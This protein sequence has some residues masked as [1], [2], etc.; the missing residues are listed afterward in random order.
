MSDDELVALLR[1]AD[2]LVHAS[3]HEG[4][5]FPPLEAMA[6]GTP[7]VALRASSVPE[8]VGDA[9]ELAAPGELGAALA[10]VLGD[11]GLR[12]ELRERGLARAADFTWERCAELTVAAYREARDG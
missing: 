7:V 11:P 1:G 2:A 9:G 4:F 10:R 12:A 6:C 5:G 3:A 8:V